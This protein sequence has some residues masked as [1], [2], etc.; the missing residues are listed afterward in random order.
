MTPEDWPPVVL[1][2]DAAALERALR[3]WQAAGVVGM[4]T[5][6]NSFY[7]YWDRLCL[8][9]VSTEDQDYIVDP[10]ALGE[11]LHRVVPLLEDPEVVK[12]FHAAEFDLMLLRKDLGAKVRG[13][14]DTQVAMTLLQHQRTG[15]AALIESIYGL[16]LSKKEQ[17]SNWGRRPL[18]PSQIDYARIDTHFLVD[19]RRRLLPELE[20]KGMLGAAE[21]EFRR[22]EEEVLPPREPDLEGWRR[23]KGARDL[24]PET[25]A[26]LRALFVWRE[27]TAQEADVPPFRVLGNEALLDLAR[28]PPRDLR[29][30]AGRKG[31]GWRKARQAGEAILG[32]LLEARDERVDDLR[33]KRLDPAER[34]RRRTERE[35][36]EALRQWRKRAARE[37]GLPSERLLHRRHL[38]AIGK[39]L[40]RSSEELL[41]VVPL[42]DWQREHLEASLL[43]VL[44]RLPDPE[45]A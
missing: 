30:L 29:E 38:E 35:N 43:E 44:E 8:L 18:S 10:L 16:Q 11:D 37:L 4:D 41:K 28:R 40:P 21:G 17:R 31:V 12:I 42:N 19:L 39:R 32:A 15:L 5:E 14:F 23:L 13:L 36:L 9:Q 7:A 2:E 1:V 33:P 24:D 45:Q 34:R 22:L 27:R 3:E 20:E 25:A 6:S 26:R